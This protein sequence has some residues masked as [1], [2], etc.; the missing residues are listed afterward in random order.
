MA[1]NSAWENQR[2]WHLG[3]I[4]QPGRFSLL[5]L[6]LAPDFFGNL[7]LAQIRRSLN[8]R[9]SI[10]PSGGQII[11]VQLLQLHLCHEGAGCHRR[12]EG[13]FINAS[14]IQCGE[15]G[16]WLSG[17]LHAPSRAARRTAGIAAQQ[18]GIQRILNMRAQLLIRHAERG[19]PLGA[20]RFA[21]NDAG[22]FGAEVARNRRCIRVHTE[23]ADGL[24]DMLSRQARDAAGCRAFQGAA[25][26]QYCLGRIS[27][28]RR[29]G[30]QVAGEFFIGS[31]EAAE[32][33]P[34][35]FGACHQPL[36]GRRQVA[37][38]LRASQL[39][40]SGIAGCAP[41]QGRL[42]KAAGRWLARILHVGN[43]LISKGDAV[44]G[45]AVSEFLTANGR[46][47]YGLIAFSDGTWL[48]TH[49]PWHWPLFLEQTLDFI[50]RHQRIVRRK[51]E[52]RRILR[53]RDAALRQMRLQVD[54]FGTI[55]Q[56]SDIG[57]MHATLDRNRWKFRQCST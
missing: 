15:H 26:F 56:R 55:N 4:A 37:A 16:L 42:I 27:N 3:Q 22:K 38:H 48:C 6:E 45:E 12:A 53:R 40:A 9:R 20:R 46:R 43:A 47:L 49:G 29:A 23:R 52:V 18:S 14:R 41:R 31:A 57:R 50:R 32:R 10:L 8:R 44:D 17:L 19:C 30:I 33:G 1:V 51:I 2:S 28:A 5:S 35:L 54:M 11:S 25:C 39:R 34:D 36:A 13:D 7:R 24:P 21:G